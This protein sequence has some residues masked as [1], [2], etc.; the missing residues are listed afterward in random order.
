MLG[1]SSVSET[2]PLIKRILNNQPYKVLIGCFINTFI[3]K[4]FFNSFR[5]LRKYPPTLISL[6]LYYLFSVLYDKENSSI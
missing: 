4:H 2:L 5:V 6:T 1:K 3:I